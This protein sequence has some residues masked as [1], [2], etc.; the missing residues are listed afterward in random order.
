MQKCA[1]VAFATNMNEVMGKPRQRVATVVT[2]LDGA[3]REGTG[4]CESVRPSMPEHRDCAWEFA[5]AG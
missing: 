4:S 5:P 1:P 2:C 3:T